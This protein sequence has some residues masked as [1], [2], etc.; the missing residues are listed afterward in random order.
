M[1][2]KKYTRRG[3]VFLIPEKGVHKRKNCRFHTGNRLFL[4][5]EKG[6]NTISG[7]DGSTIY[8]TNRLKDIQHIVFFS[9]LRF[10]H[11]DEE[12]YRKMTD[13]PLISLYM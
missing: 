9:F 10:W 5:P 6:D 13:K 8:M 4:F 2:S 12:N 11:I 7:K 3:S 1:E